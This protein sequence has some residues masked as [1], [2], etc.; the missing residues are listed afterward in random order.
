MITRAILEI[1]DF[2]SNSLVIANNELD[3]SLETVYKYVE[4]TLS[5][6]KQ[7]ANGR[8]GKFKEDNKV[9]PLFDAYKNKELDFVHFTSKVTKDLINIL[10]N[11]DD[12]KS[13]D[14]MFVE[15]HEGEEPYLGIIFL[16]NKDAIMHYVEQKDGKISNLIIKNFAI[17]PTSSVNFSTYALINLNNYSVFSQEK[18]REIN[19]EPHKILEEYLNTTYSLSNNETYRI[20]KNVINTVAMHNDISPT[21]AITKAKSFLASKGEIKELP[22]EDIAEHVFD[23]TLAK[24]EFTASMH[25]KALFNN[26]SLDHNYLMK[27]TLTHKIKTDTGIEIIFLS[28]CFDNEEHL[29][30][31]N[32]PDGTI[33]IRLKNIGKIINR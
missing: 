31:I 24:E 16:E 3:L 5:K 4:E 8:N 21:L 14:I 22:C 23:S 11:Q 26:I 32:E 30:F 1:L 33:S 12:K 28:E 9:M 19:K 10:E 7:N 6:V 15:Y 18:T 17:L 27:K 2:R 20:I 13:L 29:E 25:N